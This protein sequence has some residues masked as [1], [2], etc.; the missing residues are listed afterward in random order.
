VP[1]RFRNS[2]ITKMNRPTQ[3]CADHEH[4]WSTRGHFAVV[5]CMRCGLTLSASFATTLR[6][7]AQLPVTAEPDV[8]A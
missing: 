5:Y 6:Q 8:T 3:Y 1:F 7:I 4:T 2:A